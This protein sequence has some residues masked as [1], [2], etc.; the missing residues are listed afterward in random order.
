[1]KDE[2][3]NNQ[4]IENESLDN[5]T[6]D[7]NINEEVAE[8]TV[9]PDDSEQIYMP[10][11]NNR[12]R[13]D[14][15]SLID[16]KTGRDASKNNNLANSGDES[17]SDDKTGVKPNKNHY[18]N[19]AKDNSDLNIPSSEA[20]KTESSPK[21]NPAAGVADFANKINTARAAADLMEN[22]EEAKEAAKEVAKVQIKKKLK[23]KIIAVIMENPWI[24][25]VVGIIILL[26]I[27]IIVLIAV[28]SANQNT[29]NNST[30]SEMGDAPIS[31]TTTPLSKTEFVTALQNYNSSNSNYA[32]LRDNAEL[33]YDLGI[34]Y[35]I[36]PELAVI[37]AE[38]EGYSPGRNYNYWGIGCYNSA[39]TCRGSYDSLQNGLIAFYS[40]IK[41]YNTES[42]Y[43]VMGKYAYIGDHWYSPGSSSRG[44]CYYYPYIR[45]YL[46]ELRDA[47]VGASCNSGSEIKTTD[48][49]Q[50]AYAKYQVNNGTM[51]KRQRIFNLG[52][53]DVQVCTQQ[54]VNID[55]NPTDTSSTPIMTSNDGTVETIL[56]SHGSS[57]K[58]F[59]DTLKANTVSKGIGS[60]QAVAEA[61]S[62]LINTFETYGYRLPYSYSGGWG[63]GYNNNPAVTSYYG[64]NPGMGASINNGSGY[65][66]QFDSG[67]TTYYYVGLDCSGFVAWALRNGGINAPVIGASQYDAIDGSV[68]HNA[69]STSFIGQAGDVLANKHH[70]ILILRYNEADQSYTIAEAKGKKYGILISN[71]PISTLGSYRV[72]DMSSYYNSKVNGNYEND[73]ESG[74]KG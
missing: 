57:V 5:N 50:L 47:E 6:I 8:E 18:T 26:L 43:E 13:K 7:E 48:E 22:P 67:P 56:A 4:N 69:N 38:L 44:G 28:I 10:A 12:Y 46:S 9:I 60:R 40:T 30:C 72:V 34:E 20:P 1:M 65:T 31:V 39:S 33:V 27:M 59:N 66:I 21:A 23:E 71:A 63:G 2:E 29:S 53:D 17:S 55:A 19:K 36:N 68:Q 37:R 49:D 45:E 74:R 25:A 51:S 14:I 52:A 41:S 42:I 62:L 73:F 58:Q 64:I 70:V 11:Q 32:V 35:G 16:Y 61:A 15:Q 54:E 24:L 3:L